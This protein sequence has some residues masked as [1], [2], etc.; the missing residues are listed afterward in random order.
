VAF[1]LV[2]YAGGTAPFEGGGRGATSERD[3]VERAMPFDTPLPD[4]LEFVAA[5]P[6]AKLPYHIEYKSPLAPAPLGA[7]IQ[8]SLRDSPKW[9]LTQF[10]DLGAPFDTTLARIGS[11]GLMTHFAV[12][13][14][15]DGEGGSTLTFDFVPMDEID[16]ALP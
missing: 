10:T 4:D 1:L 9:E 16:G 15:R 2:A 8:A 13:T 14:L 5:G 3:R 6:G 11:N 12:M 7:A